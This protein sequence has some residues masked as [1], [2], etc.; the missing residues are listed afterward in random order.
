MLILGLNHGEISSSAS[1]LKNSKIIASS[2][3]ERFSR[4]KKTKSFPH[5]AIN[6]CL[7]SGNCPQ[8]YFPT[9]LIFIYLKK[10]F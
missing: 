4:I 7:K 3:E 1:I 2:G 9:F 8:G 5:N 6:F 10:L